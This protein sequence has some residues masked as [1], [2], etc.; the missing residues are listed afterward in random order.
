MWQDNET[1]QDLLGYQVHADL[2]K[3]IILN[4][5]MLPISIGVFGNWGSGKSSLMLLLQQSLK[6]WEKSPLNE[7]HKMI[8]QIYFNSWQFESYDST[9]LTMIESILEAINKDINKRKDVF[10]RADDFL[11][12]ID[13]LKAGV[14]I[15]KKAYDNLTPDWLKKWLPTKEDLD[16]ITD[17]DNYQNLLDDVTKGNTSKFIATFRELF[18]KLVDDIGYKA[19]IVYVDDL[20][21]CDPKRIIGCLE[22]VKLFV[23]VNKTA[24]IIGADERIIEYAISQHYPIPMKKEDISSPFSDYLEKLIQLPYKLPR[25][26]D[27][28]QETYITLLLCKNHLTNI[29]FNEVHQKYLEFRKTDKH[30]KYNIDDIKAN[31]PQNKNIDFHAVE[32][33][34]PTVPL[35]KRFLNGNP[36]QLKRFLNTLYVRQELAEVAGFTDIL[37]EVLTK[38]MVLEYNTLYNSRFEELYKLQNANGGVLPLDDVEQEAKTENGIQNPQWKDNWSS[39]YLRQ[40]LSSD[41]SLKNINLQNYFWVARDALK[42]EKPIASLVTNKVMLLFRRLCTLQAN[43]T[44]KRDLPGIINTC[45]DSEKDM[46]IRLIND[47]LKKDPK[48]ENCWRILNCDENNLLICDKIDRLKL[49]FNNIKTDSIDTKA[50]V[51]F[52]RMLPLNDE[53]HNYIETLPKGNPLKNAIERK[54]RK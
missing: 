11:K 42:N 40:W 23:N 41:P 9:K 38:L 47:S 6:E 54:M 52:A 48:S 3:K 50:D 24:F 35:I 37:P 26:S 4:D 27:N 19:V 25:L 32:Y 39:D 21:R 15:L 34:L 33:R 53:I 20:D 46:I 49:L 29:H 18:E 1:T 36:R 7:H 10:E 17:N 43:V 28:E 30:S 45:D 2:L 22:A 12:R 51:F 16:K 14:F 44:M 5:A 13:F 8:L 31:V